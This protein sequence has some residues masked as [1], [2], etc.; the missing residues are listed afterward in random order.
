MCRWCAWDSNQQPQDGR[1]R[2]NNGAMARLLVKVA[3]CGIK[4]WVNMWAGRAVVVAQ[5][6][7]QLL[8]SPED[9]GSKP[10]ISNFYKEPYI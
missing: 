9:S 3:V 4:K 8:P 6:A 2:Q 10:A 7:E 5:W 1:C